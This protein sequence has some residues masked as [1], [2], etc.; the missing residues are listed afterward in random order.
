MKTVGH[1]I[2]SLA[3][4]TGLVGQGAFALVADELTPDRVSVLEERLRVA[5]LSSDTDE[6]DALIDDDLLFVNHLNVLQTKAQDIEAHRS[7]ALDIRTLT[8]VDQVIKSFGPV[9]VVAVCVEME[10]RYLD[11][12]FETR[13]RFTRTWALIGQEARVVGLHVSLVFDESTPEA[14]V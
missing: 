10:G 3:L 6:L 1:H 13:A 5:M 11:E 4:A 8:P 14:C 7:G 9:A 12:P 2:A